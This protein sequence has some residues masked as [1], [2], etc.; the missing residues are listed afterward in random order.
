MMLPLSR[1]GRF[2]VAAG[3]RMYAPAA[4]FSLFES[5]ELTTPAQIRGA[6]GL[7]DWSQTKLAEESGGTPMTIKRIE[8]DESARVSAETVEKVAEALRIAGVE[9]IA[10]DGGGVGVLLQKGKP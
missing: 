1:S 6:R 9:F 7:L 3:R 2:T 10:K 4:V 8:G 5:I